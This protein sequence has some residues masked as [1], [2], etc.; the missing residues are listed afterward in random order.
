MNT[1]DSI[2][3]HY[4]PQQRA[5]LLPAMQA[6]QVLNG[7]LSRETIAHVAHGL[8]VPLAEAYGVV[9]FY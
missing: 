3:A 9:K 8:G 7:W 2:I 5:G 1:L 4:A 6:A